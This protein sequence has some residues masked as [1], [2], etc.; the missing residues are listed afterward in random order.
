MTYPPGS[1]YG[2]PQQQPVGGQSQWWETP[3]QRGGPGSWEPQ[4]QWAAAP[5]PPPPRGGKTKWILAS[6]ATIAVIMLTAIVTVVAV[7]S[8]HGDV[9][10]GAPEGSGPELASANDTGPI[11]IIT[12]EPTCGAWSKVS[13]E[14]YQIAVSVKF[15]DRD[16]AIPQSSWT[17]GQRDM[18]ETMKNALTHQV[19]QTTKLV[20]QTPHRA[21][22]VLY[23]QFIAYA[24]TYIDR[25]PSYVDDDDN[26]V[27]ASNA[28]SAAVL[29]LCSAIT[30]R[31]AQA[32]A[33]LTTAVDQP[34]NTH[35]EEGSSSPTKMITKSGSVC[36]EWNQA[37]KKFDAAAESW[38][39]IDNKIPA[40]DWTPEQKSIEEAIGPVMAT[41]ADELERLGRQSANASLEDIATL[42]A[43]Y[44]RAFVAVIPT[45]ISNDAYL[46]LTAVQLARMVNA[47]CKS[48]S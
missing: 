29:H 16:P 31:S 33:P 18:Y 6:L 14:Y 41:Y 23:Q 40:K 17:A 48:P 19:E 44:R 39:A 20:P 3:D 8:D 32:V 27:R 4:Q 13:D 26:L 42:A 43:V 22:R 24:Q 2:A 36:S 46:Q 25:L 35:E 45:Y 12:D 11:T 10:N 21:V 9:G 47:A 7:R 30:R 5:P 28:A 37:S 15:D 38:R 1:H 34:T